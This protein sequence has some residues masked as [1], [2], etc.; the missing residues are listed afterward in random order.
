MGQEVVLAGRIMNLS[1]VEGIHVLNKSSG[2][3][4]VTSE[5][6]EFY[7]K[8]KLLDTLFFSSIKYV[9]AIVV[10]S[11]DIY[12]T[13]KL[14]LT[15]ADENQLEEVYLWP[16]L[17]G[18]I[19]TD[20]KKIKI[21]EQITASDL[22]IPAFE[23]IPE[24]KIVPIVPYLGIASAVDLEALY[25]HLSGYYKT[26]KTKR[27]WDKENT[28]VSSIINFYGP[29]FFEEAYKIPEDKLI[30]FLLFCSET[31]DLTK[32]FNNAN[33]ANVLEIFHEKAP[34]YLSRRSE[35]GE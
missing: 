1:E 2:F 14:L 26:L 24:E 28:S 33:Y 18:N 29:F 4:T 32:N 13:Q 31:S 34:I 19:A 27:K 30:D 8:A 25:K 12:T 5:G 7:I 17:T 9:P 15:L 22:G 3:N 20:I 11:K 16:N 21:E 6:G 35:K 10:V 23:G